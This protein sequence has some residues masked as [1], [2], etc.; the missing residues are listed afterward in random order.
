[1][2]HNI[3]G[4]FKKKI[5][6]FTYNMRLFPKYMREVSCNKIK[7]SKLMKE[8]IMQM[9]NIYKD[10]KGYFFYQGHGDNIEN[11]YNHNLLNDYKD[12]I[13]EVFHSNKNWDNI[14]NSENLACVL[15]KFVFCIIT[16]QYP[17]PVTNVVVREI[18]Y[19]CKKYYIPKCIL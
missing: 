17:Y 11:L 14:Y 3:L 4:H 10:S 8:I 9:K 1:M 13:K 2:K 12:K 7:A 16:K 19:C 18:N 5:I 6:I 15:L